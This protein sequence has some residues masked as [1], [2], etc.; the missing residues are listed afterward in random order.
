MASVQMLYGLPVSANK[1][2]DL[3]ALWDE[4]APLGAII[5]ILVDHIDQVKLLNE[6]EKAR[7]NPRRWS[8]FVKIDAGYQCVYLPGTQPALLLT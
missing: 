4:I 8:V 6:Y 5:R 3:S 7:Q 1:L 2:D